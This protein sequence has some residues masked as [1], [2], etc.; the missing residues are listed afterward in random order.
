MKTWKAWSWKLDNV[1]NFVFDILQA[2]S[3]AI[4]D[5]IRIKNANVHHEQSQGKKT[6]SLNFGYFGRT[7]ITIIALFENLFWKHILFVLIEFE[8]F[9]NGFIVKAIAMV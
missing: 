4:L 6:K 5:R 1:E 9:R 7:N 8:V 3:R 2:S